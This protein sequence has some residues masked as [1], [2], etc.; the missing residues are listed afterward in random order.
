VTGGAG[1]R[2]VRIEEGELVMSK[3]LVGLAVVAAATGTLATS[4]I[5]TLLTDPTTIAAAFGQGSL[6]LLFA[7]LVGAV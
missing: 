6:R 1:A 7:A 5:W 3:M 4:L 2:I